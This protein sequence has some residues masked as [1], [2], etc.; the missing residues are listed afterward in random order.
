M[1]SF[2]KIFFVVWS[3]LAL[4]TLVIS[5]LAYVAIRETGFMNVS[6]RDRSEGLTIRIPVP[7]LPV[8]IVANVIGT[9]PVRITWS[10]SNTGEVGPALHAMLTEIDSAPDAT[11]LTVQDGRDRVTVRKEKGLFVVHVDDGWDEVKITVPVRT[12]RRIA[13]ALR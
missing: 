8:H 1:K 7:V 12:A 11:L 9:F 2:L 13:W 3:V 6:V 4:G 10:D 5:L